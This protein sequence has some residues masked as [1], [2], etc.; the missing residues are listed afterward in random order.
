MSIVKTK[1]MSKQNNIGSK[2]HNYKIQKFALGNQIS[3]RTVTD[4][5]LNVTGKHLIAFILSFMWE[6]P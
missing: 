6:V 2:V 5:V 3:S 4:P 1:C